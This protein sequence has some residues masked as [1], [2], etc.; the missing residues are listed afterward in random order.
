[1][2]ICWNIKLDITKTHTHIFLNRIPTLNMSFLVLVTLSAT[3]FSNVIWW[4]KLKLVSFLTELPFY[5]F[6]IEGHIGIYTGFVWHATSNAPWHNPCEK[7]ATL[8][9]STA[10]TLR[11]DKKISNSWCLGIDSTIYTMTWIAI[12]DS[13]K[14]AV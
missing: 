12:Q 1:M 13:V 7:L 6:I 11:E 9:R 5:P 3:F 2:N 8:Q 10:V 4:I 14:N